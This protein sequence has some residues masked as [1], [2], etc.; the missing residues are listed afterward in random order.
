MAASK[1]HISSQTFFVFYIKMVKLPPITKKSFHRSLEEQSVMRITKI[2]ALFPGL[3]NLVPLF[4][5]QLV[6]LYKKKTLLLA[7]VHL[8]LNKVRRSFCFQIK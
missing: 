3:V 5:K 6:Q 1:K 4:K 7:L 2:W 8:L